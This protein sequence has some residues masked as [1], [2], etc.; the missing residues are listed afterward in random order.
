[1][2]CNRAVIQCDIRPNSVETDSVI[3]FL[4]RGD[5][6]FCGQLIIHACRVPDGIAGYVRAPLSFNARARVDHVRAIWWSL[7][8][9]IFRG[10]SSLLLWSEACLP[11]PRFVAF[12]ADLSL[13]EPSFG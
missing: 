4:L 10:C 12:V 6:K 7:V 1:M 8:W 3:A 11:R 13:R 2:A 9:E 5:V